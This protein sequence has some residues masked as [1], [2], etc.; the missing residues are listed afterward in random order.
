[1]FLII[2]LLAAVVIVVQVKRRRGIRV[3]NV[4][5]GVGGAVVLLFTAI[6]LAKIAA[7]VYG[8]WDPDPRANTSGELAEYIAPS[9]ASFAIVALAG[10]AVLLAFGYRWLAHRVGPTELGLGFVVVWLGLSALAYAVTPVGAYVFQ[11]PTLAA[12]GAW[13]W[14]AQDP[15]RDGF[16]LVVPAAVAVFLLTPQVLLSY[17][18]GGVAVLPMVAVASLVIGFIGPALTGMASE[19]APAAKATASS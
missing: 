16:L 13:L 12:V 14:L 3:R 2:A 1:V 15:R 10:I 19:Q 11:L 18:G 6:A 7:A 8:H 5:V 17:F 9:S 4:A